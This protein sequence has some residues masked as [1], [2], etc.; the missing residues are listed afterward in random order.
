MKFTTYGHTSKTYVKSNE[1]SKYI[2]ENYLERVERE[3]KE[4]PEKHPGALLLDSS[5][6][7]PTQYDYKIIECGKYFQIYKYENKKTSQ[8]DKREKTMIDYDYLFTKRENIYSQD[9]KYIQVKNINRSVNQVKRLVKTNEEVF[10]TFITLT[11]A[12]NVTDITDANKKFDIWRTK[13][14]SI[15]KDFCYVGVPE[16]Q[17]RG[18][19]H[20]HLLT[21]L[22]IEKIYQ[23]TRRGKITE[24]QLIIPQKEFTEKQLKK[25]TREQKKHCYNVK[26]WSYG[27]TSVY[28]LENINVVGYLTKYMTKDIDNR[29]WGHRKYFYSMNLKRPKEILID[30][31]IAKEYSRIFLIENLYDLKYQKIYFDKCEN[32]IQFFEYKLEV[33]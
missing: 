30:S 26:Y 24:T 31:D 11:F 25:M 28:P 14:K 9:K 10:K 5:L 1:E 12:D 22:E 19:V 32:E 23:Y 2:K 4:I 33:T 16:F 8:K 27:F 18:A 29:L 3:F 20:Y 17:K 13:I 15:F 6:I 21:N 7:T